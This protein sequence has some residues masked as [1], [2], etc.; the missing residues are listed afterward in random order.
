[1]NAFAQAQV[2]SHDGMGASRL[3][4][5]VRDLNVWFGQDGDSRRH[6]VKGVD[7]EL[8]AGQCIALVGE[9]G[10]GKSVTA[11]SLIGLAGA[12]SRVEAA[13]LTF[14]GE[15]LL[16]R[17][18]RWWRH[19]R[20][21]K[22]GLILQDALV[23][24][25]PLR[26]V[27]KE[28]DEA[29][30]LHRWGDRASRREKILKILGQVGV[31]EPAL[32]AKQ[33]SGELSGGLRQRAL[34]AAAIALHPNVVIADEPT[35]ALDVTVQAQVLGVLKQM[36]ARGTSIILISH[37]LAVVSKL[38][39]IIY[40]MRGGSIV[41]AGPRDRVLN[42][43]RHRYTQ[44]LIDAVPSEHT[45]GTRL[46]ADGGVLRPG[47]FSQSRGRSSN[48]RVPLLDAR[49]IV[50]TFRSPDGIRRTVVKGVSFT[51]A[52]GETLGIVG[53]SGSG[54]STLARVALSLETPDS[55]EVRFEG[56][57]WT[58]AVPAEQRQIR[59]RISVVY[60]DPLSSFD[61][62]WRVSRILTDAITLANPSRAQDA[63]QYAAAL[64]EAVGLEPVHL[65]RWPLQMSGGQR[66]RVAIAR[67]IATE[68][69]IIILDEA[70]SA[71]DVSVQAQILDLLTDLQAQ[72]GIS[73]LFI[74][75]DLGVIHHMSDRV[76][77][78]KDG[79]AVEQGTADQVFYHPKHAYTQ[80]L[81]AS[82]PRLEYAQL[83]MAASA[84]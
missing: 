13:N 84:R 42:R 30:W 68:P 76:L 48:N 37:D 15:T 8:Y 67:A 69:E 5:E 19:V 49:N 16:G 46:S 26:P 75:H 28:I 39:D 6:V 33:R 35:T 79:K 10:S 3:I 54:K 11:R 56:R 72:L 12:G 45:K 34:I 21:S 7:L 71:L 23:S 57:I 83:R 62:R 50:K 60:Q 44:Q 78:M 82:L 53:E 47:L 74:S 80:S 24:L 59:K 22:I 41:E 25:D 18:D 38:A 17:S 63:R 27:G 77:V 70:V 52:R 61:P 55:G 73:Y 64:L 20:G 40:V 9:S 58:G 66:Q 31:P 36:L 2:M 29:L 43:P 65:D 32:R 51:L 14:E 4:L 81:L 1:M